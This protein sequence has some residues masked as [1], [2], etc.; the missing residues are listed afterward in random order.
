MF[1]EDPSRNVS[2]VDQVT[3]L[4]NRYNELAEDVKSLEE[5]HKKREQ[6]VN[7]FRAEINNDLQGLRQRLGEVK[8]L[9]DRA[10]KQRLNVGS[11]FKQ[12]IK[13]DQFSKLA[14]RIDSLNFEDKISRDELYRLIER[15]T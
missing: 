1:M 15:K 9:V 4:I 5:A 14:K 3:A 12:I 6:E 13:R 8:S 11:D 10:A 7:L 2:I